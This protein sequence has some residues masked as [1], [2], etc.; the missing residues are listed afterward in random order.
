MIDEYAQSAVKALLYEVSVQPK[1]GLVD[2]LGHLSHPDM[3]VFTFIDSSLS[4]TR[5]FQQVAHAGLAYSG[6]DLR[7]LFYQI[8]P[9]GIQAEQD[10]LAVTHGINTHKGAIFSLGIVVAAS[11]YEQSLDSQ[12]ILCVVKQMM[13]G[14][15]EHD[16]GQLNEI[17][18]AGE[19]Q[20]SK[21]GLT[22]SRGQAEQGFPIV[23]EF[24]LP[25]L[26]QA[27]G[28]LNDRLIDTL[29]MI[30]RH[31]QDSNLIKRA[32]NLAI[33]EK[34]NRQI[35]LYFQL[36]ASNSTAGQKQLQ[37][38]NLFFDEKNLSLGGSADLLI[39]TIY[40]A[41]IEKII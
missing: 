39:L 31:T 33:I 35:D 7:N 2:P 27:T 14:I 23:S 34:V 8:R 5:Y 15:V 28:S 3:T 22:G 40:F 29:L 9:L 16:L 1:P 36:G 12:K 11:G 41:L 30:A 10:M 26:K 13:V 32:G 25:F 21:Y 38:I 4:L 37:K 24:A 6:Q 19:M 17:R 20:F 18:T